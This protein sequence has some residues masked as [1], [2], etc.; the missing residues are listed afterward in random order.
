MMKKKQI[1]LII[2][3]SALSLL[4]LLA[5]QLNWIWQAAQ[6]RQSQLK[7]RI[8]MAS[9]WIEKQ[10]G[11]DSLIQ[12]HLS[13]V[14]IENRGEMLV[15]PIQDHIQE[16]IDTLLKTQFRYY[17]VNIAFD[18][19]LV[20][21]RNDDYMATC[22]TSLDAHGLSLDQMVKPQRGE[23]RIAFPNTFSLVI[24]QMGWML[25]TSLIL[26]SL[27]MACFAWTIRT[28]WKQ[29]KISEMTSDFINNMTHE[30]KTPISTVSLAS[31]ML[32]KDKVAN[33]PEKVVHYSQMIHEENLKLQ[34]QVEQVLRIAKMERGD[35][36]LKLEPTNI[37][38]VI[39]KA[40]HSIDLQ[41][42]NRNGQIRCYLHAVKNEIV[43]DV[44]HVTNVISNLLDN[45]NKYSPDTPDITIETHN[46]ENGVVISVQD[47]GIGMSKDKQKYI[48]NKFYRVPTGNIHDVKGFGLGLA[49]V[50]MMVDAHKGQISLNSEPGKGSRFDIFLPFN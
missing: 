46:R 12:N 30:L 4:G 6:L 16:R 9:S 18:F 19:H 28:I 34:D 22:K 11:K 20:D 38:D 3:V 37:N 15:V 45:A 48:F 29:K 50:K 13:E 39:Q 42:Q 36:S 17:Q 7:H 5:F 24:T 2:F 23:L 35:I 31:N 25:L 1:N 27:V 44:N 33:N 26:I 21:K 41:V 10:M 14:L 8:A 32:K 47:K 43:A 49:Y 40:I